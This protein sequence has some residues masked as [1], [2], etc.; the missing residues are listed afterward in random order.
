MPGPIA[1]QTENTVESTPVNENAQNQISGAPLAVS[2][3]PNPKD[4]YVAKDNL[5]IRNGGIE[6]A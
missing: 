2:I 3:D 4:G 5:F 6:D 1:K